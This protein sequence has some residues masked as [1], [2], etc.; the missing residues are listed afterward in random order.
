MP[1]WQEHFDVAMYDHDHSYDAGSVVITDNRFGEKARYQQI[2]KHNYRIILPYLMDSDVNDTCETVNGEFVLR[3]RDWIW[4]QESLQWRHLNYHA[5]CAPY[6]PSKFFLLLMNLKKANRDAL[7]QAVGPYLESSTYSYV[8][9]GITLPGDQFVVNPF[10]KG[11]ANDRLYVP[12]WYT[13]TCF[14]L[15]SETKII[16]K[17]FISEKIFKPLAYHHPLVVYGSPGTLEYIR[18]CG[19]ETFGHRVNESY[20]SIPNT[21]LH[22]ARDRLN[23]VVAVLED[24][25]V[26]FKQTGTVFQDTR[27]QQIL[28]HNHELFFDQTRVHDMFRDQ[29]VAPIME[30]VESQ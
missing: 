17:L 5:P 10:N 14:S 27:T 8:E 13:Q 18:S 6:A 12:D 19:F 25:Y 22:V 29:V 24:L 28:A 23:H 7:F 9:R 1:L 15:V 4:I 30:F 21:G 26:E 20:D 3:A 2:Q 11:T 16:S